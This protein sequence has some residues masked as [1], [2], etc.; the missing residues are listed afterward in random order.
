MGLVSTKF[1]LVWTFFISH[2]TW[3]EQKK[4]NCSSRG[5]CFSK[6]I[7]SHWHVPH[8]R[9]GKEGKEAALGGPILRPRKRQIGI[10]WDNQF[11]K[12]HIGNRQL[13]YQPQ[14]VSRIIHLAKN[15][16]LTPSAK[17]WANLYAWSHQSS[18]DSCLQKTPQFDTHAHNTYNIF[19]Y[20]YTDI[21][22]W[23]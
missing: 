11:N 21:A 1:I 7:I 19:T 18:Q 8:T 10:M 17:S 4:V 12:F 13:V 9:E 14:L 15:G 22:H 20:F 16:S 23:D 3:R 2:A 6:S 5:I